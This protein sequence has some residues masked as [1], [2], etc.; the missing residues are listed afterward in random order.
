MIES[1]KNKLFVK[2]DVLLV[3]ASN[4]ATLSTLR[5]TRIYISMINH[6][7]KTAGYVRK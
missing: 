5:S 4:D 7:N 6:N 1:G 3:F 2:K